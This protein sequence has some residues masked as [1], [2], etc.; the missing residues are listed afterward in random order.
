MSNVSWLAEN[1][2]HTH[3]N[4]HKHAAHESRDCQ[5]SA[6]KYLRECYLQHSVYLRFWNT[7]VYGITIVKLVINKQV[8]DS[9]SCFG[10]VS[11]V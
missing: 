1:M 11:D 9:T 8:S 3:T 4:T 5:T 10:I 2:K 6:V 7:V